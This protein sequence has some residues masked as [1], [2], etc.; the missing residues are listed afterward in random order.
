M[1]GNYIYTINCQEGFQ[2]KTGFRNES[3]FKILDEIILI[4]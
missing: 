1:Q 3:R 4:A 2:K